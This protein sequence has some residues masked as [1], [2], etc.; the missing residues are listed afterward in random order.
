[1]MQCTVADDPLAVPGGAK[2]GGVKLAGHC[3]AQFN[4]SL[5]KHGRWWNHRAERW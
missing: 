1:M 3:A 4:N 5:G 2:P